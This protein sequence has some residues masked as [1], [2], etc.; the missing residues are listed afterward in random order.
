[1][2]ARVSRLKLAVAWQSAAGRE[3]AQAAA[4]VAEELGAPLAADAAEDPD[5]LIEVGAS[6]CCLR[7]LRDRRARPLA[8][9]FLPAPGRFRRFPIARRNVFARALGR[10]TRRVIDA[11]AGW[12][13]D[14]ALML[15][16][17]M[18]VVAVE[19]S[20]VM[21]ALLRDA[22]LRWRRARDDVSGS[23]PD[24]QV[25]VEDALTYLAAEASRVDCV[26][27]DPMFPARRR[28][29]ALASRPV[30]LLRD[31]VGD[32][33]DARRLLA[34]ALDANAKRV[35]VKRP[36]DGAVLGPAPDETFGGKMVRYDVYLGTPRADQA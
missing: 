11:T 6:G 31:L 1:M 20:P 12:G 17:G 33:Q 15:W 35:V 18:D 25:V 30:R 23:W 36:D 29:S 22:A 4:A 26:Y 34:A 5:L 16:M 9:D 19:R 8:V 14:A 24:I 7:D 21:G 27:L 13:R 28:A 3:A 32:D 2:R 10:R